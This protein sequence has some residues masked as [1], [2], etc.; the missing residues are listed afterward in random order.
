MNRISLFILIL[1][2][3]LISREIYYTR[4]GKVSFSSS[5]PL[6][7]IRAFN[8]QAT[9]VFD[10][11]S[12]EVSFQIPI[13]GFTF[14]NGLMQEHFNENYMETHLFPNAIF[15]GRIKN[16]SEL[17]INSQSNSV[18]INGTMTIHGI[19]KEISEI[20]SIFKQDNKIIGNAN[21]DI[22]VSDYGIEIPKIVRENIAKE[23]DVKIEVILNRK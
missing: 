12:G 5:A 1:L 18:T 14:K 13:L 16:W 23:V 6:E 9:C 11:D 3:P 10:Y 21:F 20:G 15:Q 7:D 19:S 17:D 8:E 2:T 4:F 22:I